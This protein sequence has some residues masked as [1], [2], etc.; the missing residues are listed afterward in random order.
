MR[1]K[2]AA[3]LARLLRNC[4]AF[5]LPTSLLRLG[6][7]LG[8]DLA[9]DLGSNAKAARKLPDAARQCS[10]PESRHNL[11]PAKRSEEH[12]SEL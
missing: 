8:L 4:F 3:L 6:A 2:T 9:T 5:L 12:T 1:K 11:D 10:G 7:L